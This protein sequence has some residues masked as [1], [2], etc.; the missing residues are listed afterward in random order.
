M[1]PSPD[2]KSEVMIDDIISDPRLIRS[3]SGSKRIDRNL[4]DVGTSGGQQQ[5]V[6]SHTV[7]NA[8]SGKGTASELYSIAQSPF[9]VLQHA[10]GVH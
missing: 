6:D 8:P 9:Q 5:T 3:L 2:K 7:V 1:S 4:A 10:P